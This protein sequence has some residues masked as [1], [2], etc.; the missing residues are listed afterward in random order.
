M[1]R[2]AWCGRG[3]D[4]QPHIEFHLAR[5]ARTVKLCRDCASHQPTLQTIRQEYGP[6]SVPARE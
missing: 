1:T 5:A 6:A 4:N 3:I 2:C